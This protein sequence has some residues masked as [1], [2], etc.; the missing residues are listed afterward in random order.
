MDLTPGK[1]EEM[2]QLLPAHPKI[3][4]CK[5][6]NFHRKPSSDPVVD[7]QAGCPLSDVFC[8]P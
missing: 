3:L 4:I 7:T 1:N 6:T 2:K 5:T 8:F